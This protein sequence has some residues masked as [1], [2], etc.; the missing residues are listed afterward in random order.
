[1][2]D[3]SHAFRAQAQ[4]MDCAQMLR[5]VFDVDLQRCPRCGGGN[6]KII[7]ATLQRAA[8]VRILPHLGLEPQPPPRGRAR[9]ADRD[10]SS[11]TMDL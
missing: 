2:I 7:A 1:M 11:G 10:A 5:R 6:L 3:V 4:R 8:I 9:E